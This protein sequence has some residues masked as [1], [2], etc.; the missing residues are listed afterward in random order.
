MYFL[1]IG[2]GHA[3]EAA[4]CSSAL[5]RQPVLWWW[6]L[7]RPIWAGTAFG[8]LIFVWGQCYASSHGSQSGFISV[9]KKR[10]L[11]LSSRDGQGL[12]AGRRILFVFGQNPNPAEAGFHL[13]KSCHSRFDLQ[14]GGGIDVSCGTFYSLTSN[15]KI[16]PIYLVFIIFLEV[17]DPGQ[18]P[19]ADQATLMMVPGHM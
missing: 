2:L 7:A 4:V 10:N 16:I 12:R 9:K 11:F 15:L 17:S 8:T 18:T 3:I 6:C 14:W 19:G 13:N 5:V 1:V